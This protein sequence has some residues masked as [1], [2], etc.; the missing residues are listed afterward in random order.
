MDFDLLQHVHLGSEVGSDVLMFELTDR[1]VPQ[2]EFWPQQYFPPG[3]IPQTTR[4]S[5][6]RNK[7]GAGNRRQV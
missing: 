3:Q 6:A 5:V 4:T 2:P 7:C 1:K